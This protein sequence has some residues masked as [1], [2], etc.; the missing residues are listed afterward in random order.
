M[1][2]APMTALRGIRGSRKNAIIPAGLASPPLLQRSFALESILHSARRHR[3]SYIL[4]SS[5]KNWSRPKGRSR[6][7]PTTWGRH[8][9]GNPR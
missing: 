6:N 9:P 1:A 4:F 7:A 3:K 2:I 5:T 8:S